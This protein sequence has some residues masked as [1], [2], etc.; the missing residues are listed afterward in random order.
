[1]AQVIVQ[2]FIRDV[3]SA[4][5]PLI[6]KLIRKDALLPVSETHIDPQKS[7]QF[8]LRQL[9]AWTLAT[10]PLSLNTVPAKHLAYSLLHAPTPD[11]FKVP[12]SAVDVSLSDLAE[13]FYKTA[14]RA[15]KYVLPFA[16]G[17]SSVA[18]L[19][20]CLNWL[21][22]E[23]DTPTSTEVLR[24]QFCNLIIA[25]LTQEM[26]QRIP[27]ISDRN[28]NDYGHWTPVPH[29]TRDRQAVHASLTTRSKTPMA[30]DDDI[31]KQL[32]WSTLDVQL[33]DIPKYITRTTTPTNF[34]TAMPLE[35][36][37]GY[38]LDTYQ[39]AYNFFD[40][41]NPVC[42]YAM[43]IAFVASRTCQMLRHDNK[44]PPELVSLANQGQP[45]DEASITRFVRDA[46]W[47]GVGA[48][49]STNS[50]GRNNAATQ[51]T[52]TLV[53][54]L[55]MLHR[56]S[57]LRRRMDNNEQSLGTDWTAK[58]GISIT[59]CKYSDTADMTVFSPSGQKAINGF[60][61]IRFGLAVGRNKKVF[62]SA[63]YGQD[64]E[65][66]S[67]ESVTVL[68]A[69]M[70]TLLPQPY[71][72]F[73]WLCEVVG[74]RRAADLPIDMPPNA[75]EIAQTLRQQMWAEPSPRP[76]TPAR[77]PSPPKHIT[78][79]RKAPSIPGPI[80]ISDE[81][82][83][84]ERHAPR[85]HNTP[86]TSKKRRAAISRFPPSQSVSS[87][88]SSDMGFEPKKPRKFRGM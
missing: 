21:A 63:S 34:A 40:I 5:S 56:E 4:A 61:M 57:P 45:V 41:D 50:K 74:P 22:E 35:N 51:F 48:G 8:R 85:K 69:R 26:V 75:K 60:N 72:L 59:S 13:A 23:Q 80:E 44:P 42:H 36:T 58:H 82:D 10:H 1:M 87:P 46:K 81:Y 71:G 11:L 28:K 15:R 77:S 67:L 3:T 30:D 37:S 39:W 66:I 24:D 33:N 16:K 2:S 65:V 49:G 27:G 78:L 43:W 6:E 38:F 31:A 17:F 29:N 20:V 14:N 53:Y 54:F 86:S 73:S 18:L 52:M 19:P 88:G 25:A 68:H 55:A 64:W 47:L 83:T 62:R 76:E 70:A 12:K 79:K 9:T 84:D 7:K 32:A